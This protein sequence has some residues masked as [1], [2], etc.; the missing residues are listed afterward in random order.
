MMTDELRL[1][2]ADWDRWY[3]TGH[4]SVV[5]H[6]ECDRFYG[7]VAPRPGMT[8][9]DL[10]CGSGQWTRQ[11]AAWGLTVTGY[12]FSTESLRQA[13]AAGLRDRLTYARWDIDGEAI[14]RN[15][16]P[17]SLNLVTC[18]FALP[19]LAYARLLTDVGRW[20]DPDS[21]TFYAL[22]RVD[23]Q[24]ADEGQAAD[25]EPDAAPDPF[26]RR[27]TEEQIETLGYGWAHCEMYS[28]SRRH[29][30]IVLRGYGG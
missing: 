29:R 6:K 16:L 7:R 2:P 8:A 4:P 9:V 30:A 15:L 18:R 22:V 27:L 25:T 21:G 1:S 23:R 20:L 19:Y 11:L 26:H 28:L 14:P 12:D 3:R 10:A 13:N 24:G 17:G 5:S